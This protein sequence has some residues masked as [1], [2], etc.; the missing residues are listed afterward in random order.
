MCN[1]ISCHN[2]F[3]LPHRKCTRQINGFQLAV[4]L[5]QRH[6]PSSLCSADLDPAS[7]P[8]RVS[9]YASALTHD[10]GL[11]GTRNQKKVSRSRF[12]RAGQL[13]LQLSVKKGATMTPFPAAREQGV[14][15]FFLFLFFLGPMVSHTG[16]GAIGQ[17]DRK[18]YVTHVPVYDLEKN[19]WRH[20]A[21][22]LRR[23]AVLFFSKLAELTGGL[24]PGISCRIN[25][26]VH[27]GYCLT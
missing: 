18:Q 23:G 24:G 17:V 2:R 1:L 16:R 13:D 5:S 8:G 14:D 9:Y 3:P 15:F 21:C 12:S 4:L 11:Q 27:P 26:S 22:Q 7:D 6:M 19:G 25:F 20:D 10:R